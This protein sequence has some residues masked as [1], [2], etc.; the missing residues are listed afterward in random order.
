MPSPSRCTTPLGQHRE[1]S[2]SAPD[3]IA[4]R[5]ALSGPPTAL[6][7]ATHTTSTMPSTPVTTAQVASDARE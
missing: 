3:T 5:T 4:S 1:H 7:A 2:H 6:A